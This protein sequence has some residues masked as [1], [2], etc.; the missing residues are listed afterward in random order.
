MLIGSRWRWE[1][2]TC[3]GKIIRK[4][5]SIGFKTA[6]GENWPEVQLLKALSD[7]IKSSCFIIHESRVQDVIAQEFIL[8]PLFKDVI[9]CLQLASLI[10]K[11]L[12]WERKCFTLSVY[13]Y[14]SL[15]D[16]KA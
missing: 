4:A 15:S 6:C 3:H 14:F 16:T 9:C 1:T 10:P 5:L 8:V 11:D 12:C 13:S 7:I 2:I